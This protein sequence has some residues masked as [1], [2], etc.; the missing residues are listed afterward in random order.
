MTDNTLIFPVLVHLFTAIVTLFFW[1]KTVSQRVISIVGSAVAMGVSIELFANVWTGGILTL[2][3]AGWEAPF[4]I[5][6]VADVFSS[7]MV[8]LTSFSGFAVSLYSAT[9]VARG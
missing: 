3:A 6:F 4:G 2:Q 9:G 1:R 5:S 8:L 7:S